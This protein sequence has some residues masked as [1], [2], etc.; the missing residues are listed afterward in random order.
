[1]LTILLT[2]LPARLPTCSATKPATYSFAY[3]SAYSVGISGR[4]PAELMLLKELSA[5][6]WADFWPG[7]GP[8]SSEAILASLTESCLKYFA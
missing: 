4:Q 1:M 6:L 2:T 8:A 5:T 7:A 3:S